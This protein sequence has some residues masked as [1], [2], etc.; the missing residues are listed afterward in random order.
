MPSSLHM[1]KNDSEASP[2]IP[3]ELADKYMNFVLRYF[4]Q[5]VLEEVDT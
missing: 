5:I 4:F 3:R 2:N 1:S